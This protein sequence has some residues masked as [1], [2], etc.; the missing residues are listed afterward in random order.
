MKNGGRQ[1]M[2]HRGGEEIQK[3]FGFEQGSSL[4]RG[5]NNTGLKEIECE[6]VDRIQLAQNI[7][8]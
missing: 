8:Q 2:R 3:Q 7:D 5:K 4:C 6:E 1:S